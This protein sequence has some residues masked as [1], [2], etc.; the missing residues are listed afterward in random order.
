M[1]RTVQAGSGIT[2]FPL[3]ISDE[4]LTVD[5][6]DELFGGD[7]RF[8]AKVAPIEAWCRAIVENPEPYIKEARNRGTLDAEGLQWKRDLPPDLAERLLRLLDLAKS[9]DTVGDDMALRLAFDAGIVAC[10]LSMK[11]GREKEYLKGKKQR[12]VLMDRTATH[13]QSVKRRALERH[14]I[15]AAKAVSI[16]K[17]H[18]NWRPGSIAAAVKRQLKEEVNVRTIE[19]AIKKLDTLV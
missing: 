8:A 15:W 3:T 17:A 13:N 18:P 14:K 10:Q 6:F 1:K 9:A 4:P 11:V 19:R 12:S 7:H 5:R 16:K 2:S